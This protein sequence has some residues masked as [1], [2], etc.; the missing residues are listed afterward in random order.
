MAT[1]ATMAT[2]T[3]GL[4]QRPYIRY[5]HSLNPSVCSTGSIFFHPWFSAPSSHLTD[6]TTAQ[7]GDRACLLAN[8]QL[9]LLHFHTR[10]ARDSPASDPPQS[11]RSSP[12]SRLTLDVLS[13]RL[14]NSL[15][16]DYERRTIGFPID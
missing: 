10:E 3:H 6:L 11:S 15:A 5:V 7:R 1:T 4:F 16:K 12:C 9:F 8:L 13:N 14:Q 2:T